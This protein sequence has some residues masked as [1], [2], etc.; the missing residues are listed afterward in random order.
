[1]PVP[2]YRPSRLVRV[3]DILNNHSNGIICNI[4]FSV[5]FLDYQQQIVA[6]VL[7]VCPNCAN[8]SKRVGFLFNSV[9]AF[10]PSS[11]FLISLI[12]TF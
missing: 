6:L 12:A 8:T 4:T 11:L 3:Y 10:K 7:N 2:G 9:Q 1:M 5:L